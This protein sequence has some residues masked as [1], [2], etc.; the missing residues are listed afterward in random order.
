MG[1][2]SLDRGIVTG[3]ATATYSKDVWNRSRRVQGLLGPSGDTMFYVL[4]TLAGLTV[5]VV[6]NFDNGGM[7]SGNYN[8][9]T[10]TTSTITLTNPVDSTSSLS[11]A[12]DSDNNI[13][14]AYTSSST[15]VKVVKLAPAAGNTYTKSWEENAFAVAGGYGVGLL[16]IDVSDSASGV[17]I[18]VS[19]YR[20][21]FGTVA[22]M[23]LAVR[24]TAGAWGG[25][26]TISID[27]YN[28]RLRSS[29]PDPFNGPLSIV[30]NDK[31]FTDGA[32]STTSYIHVLTRGSAYGA[33]SLYETKVDVTAAATP[34]TPVR[35]AYDFATNMKSWRDGYG[36][37]FS[38][39]DMP[40]APDN[41]VMVAVASRGVLTLMEYSGGA[42][43]SVAASS[44]SQVAPG[45]WPSAISNSR[46]YFGSGA[47]EDDLRFIGT[48]GGPNRVA[49]LCSREYSGRQVIYPVH[50]KI[51]R[52][53]IGYSGSVEWHTS[54]H[55]DYKPTGTAYDD[56]GWLISNVFDGT[57]RFLAVPDT[58]MVSGVK[59][60]LTFFCLHWKW[61]SPNEL[62]HPYFGVTRKPSTTGT[63][64][65]GGELYF[66]ADAST[67]DT[68]EFVPS[69]KDDVAAVNGYM[70]LDRGAQFE[71]SAA[72]DF[73]TILASAPAKFVGA[74]GGWS[75]VI[76]AESVVSPRLPQAATYGRYRTVDVHGL[77]SDWTDPAVHT[78]F[79]VA[80]PPVAV[81]SSPTNGAP[82]S[83]DITSPTFAWSWSDT[84]INDSQTAFQV[85]VETALG[86]AIHDS[87][88]IV[89][90]NKSYA[91][92]GMTANSDLKHWKVRTWDLDDVVGSY[93]D[94]AEFY[95]ASPP[96]ISS[97]TVD[98][99][100]PLL[101]VAWTFDTGTGY[102]GPVK[103]M[104]WILDADQNFVLASDYVVSTATTESYTWT[105]PVLDIDTDYI[106][107]VLVWDT[108]GGVGVSAQEAF[109][110]S[111]TRPATVPD[112][113]VDQSTLRTDGYLDVSWS[114]TGKDAAFVQYN[115]YSYKTSDG[116]ATMALVGSTV[117]NDI[118]DALPHVNEEVVYVVKQQIDF[119]GI[120]VESL[121]GSSAP[122]VPVDDAYWLISPDATGVP[123]ADLPTDNTSLVKIWHV[124]ADSFQE[125][126]EEEIINLMDRGRKKEIGTRY[127]YSG[128]LQ[129]S[130]KG[131]GGVDDDPREQRLTLQELRAIRNEICMR[132]PFGDIFK[133]SLG[134]PSFEREPGT[135]TMERS[136][137][138]VAYEEVS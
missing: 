1:S 126:Y 86:V 74:S 54:S 129:L 34:P 81:P 116:I 106:A 38:S 48:V 51:A 12:V 133:V 50:A 43:I 132:T 72:S 8:G 32:S 80:H 23:C 53:G 95:Y 115:V 79:T 85:V 36:A 105:T 2:T 125:E 99:T 9:T 60:R 62:F 22:W 13:Y 26:R 98:A 11:C 121:A 114:T 71:F 93:S 119:Y 5:R 35:V 21:T 31:L 27:S 134:S 46:K 10:S 3:I 102:G 25:V 100:T 57:N 24:S 107:I 111:W 88:K 123:V 52:T 33:V 17:S 39:A 61:G 20:Y 101:E 131:V 67:V 73:S 124:T 64:R 122:V 135:G 120:M 103:Y 75:D 92:P 117:D 138:S 96:A 30:F 69:G 91:V 29:A 110:T 77:P 68:S 15:Q 40:N 70:F 128:T 37:L 4:R 58:S 127:G 65:E 113:V 76:E 89:S 55:N 94:W 130:L 16:D 47:Y 7:T 42:G 19:S 78:T 90:T 44:N 18:A 45:T 118:V 104:V 41:G 63:D 109:T 6:S 97:V 59:G 137:V 112:V 108:L 56:T 87:G 83:G 14:V 28:N 84:W 136:T 82:I 66:P 49:F